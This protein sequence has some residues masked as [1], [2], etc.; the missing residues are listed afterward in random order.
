MKHIKFITVAMM[1]VLT[2]LSLIE[3]KSSPEQQLINAINDTKATKVVQLLSQ[4]S[5]NNLKLIEAALALVP[6]KSA[7]VRCMASNPNCGVSPTRKV[8]LD[9]QA[10]LQHNNELDES[11]V[12]NLFI[13]YMDAPARTATNKFDNH[14]QNNLVG[15]NPATYAPQTFTPSSQF[16][17]DGL[18]GNYF[19]ATQIATIHDPS[20]KN[21]QSYNFEKVEESSDYS[22][23]EQ[24]PQGLE[25]IGSFMTPPQCPPGMMCAQVMTVT[26]LYGKRTN[27]NHESQD[28]TITSI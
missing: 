23:N 18:I 25:F 1:L 8:L 22:I 15:S 10:A 20:S 3:A 7:Y 2:S 13:E 14:M 26:S 21:Q 11:F 28:K 4:D 27:K 12:Y 6:D 19:K 24:A 17:G 16:T 9:L 5:N